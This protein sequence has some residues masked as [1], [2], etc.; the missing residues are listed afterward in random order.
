MIGVATFTNLIAIVTMVTLFTG[1]ISE[2]S[3]N[4]G[5]PSKNSSAMSDDDTLEP[6]AIP[7]PTAIPRPDQQVFLNSEFCACYQGV[8]ALFSSNVTCPGFCGGQTDE[9][10]NLYINTTLG[11]QIE[12]NDMFGDLNN[13]C[14]VVL[15]EENGTAPGC[16]LRAIFGTEEHALQLKYN[17]IPSSN[18]IVADLTTLDPGK[19][20]IVYLEELSSGARS[21]AIHVNIKD[22]TAIPDPST[23]P[24][25]ID[26]VHMYT[27][28]E[29]GVSQTVYFNE[30][31]KTHFTYIDRNK[32]PTLMPGNTYIFCHDIQ[33]YGN[34]DSPDYPRLE[35]VESFFNVWSQQDLRMYDLDADGQPDINKLLADR[36]TAEGISGA[37]T[38]LFMK[39]EWFLY[40][41]NGLQLD[42]STPVSSAPNYWSKLGFI[43]SPWIDTNTAKAYCPTETHYNGTNPVFSILKEYVGTPT[44]GIYLAVKEPDSYNSVDEDGN[45]I[46]TA[47]PEDFLLV[48]EGLV[49]KIWFYTEN[50]IRI[51]PDESTRYTKTLM[52]HWPYDI[53]N[54]LIKQASQRTYTI[55]H[56]QDLNV[57]TQNEIPTTY[58]PGDKRL[59][60]IPAIL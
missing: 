42:G 51:T 50:G 36:Y 20:Y 13:W 4:K 55:K 27:C 14:T 56:L 12:A 8:P 47:A 3:G 38:N 48:R 18:L 37:P 41:Q 44:E 45:T 26:P 29:R 53:N 46:V 15:D 21:D 32:P 19:P 1:C 2:Y 39:W 57:A 5:R 49:T 52:F 9:Q 10:T 60:C 28:I 25:S 31:F 6:T 43:M 7:D 59:G 17:P 40:P 11:A 35:L 30:S 24:L 23:G 16:V 33:A 34:D 22:S 58:I 54:P